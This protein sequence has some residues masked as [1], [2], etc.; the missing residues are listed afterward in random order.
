MANVELLRETLQYIKNNPQSWRQDVW[1]THIDPETGRRVESV[2]EVEVEEVNSCNTAF[3]FA[4]H[5]ALKSGFPAPPKESYS[6][7]TAEI[8]GKT[9]HVDTYA[10]SKLGITYDQADVLFSG[11]NSLEDI[12]TIVEA[13]IEN[14]DI[15]DGDLEEKIGRDGADYCCDECSGY[16]DDEDEETVW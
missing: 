12:E 2:I 5:A 13:I 15:S 4:G 3:C 6:Q 9:V 8:D 16:A 7:W 11:E 1:F 14:P 10:A